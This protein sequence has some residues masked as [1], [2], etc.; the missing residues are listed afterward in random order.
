LI[1]DADIAMYNAKTDGKGRYAWFDMLMRTQAVDRWELRAD[2]RDALRRNEFFLVYQPIIDLADDRI[3]GAE[4]LLR[5]RHPT[6]G[7]IP[8]DE[9]IGVAEQSGLIVEIGEW[10]LQTAMQ[11]ASTWHAPRPGEPRPAI[12]INVSAVQLRDSEIVTC[13]RTALEQS[14]LPADTVLLELTESTLMEDVERT[15]TVLEE[16]KAL[17]VRVAV[18]DFGTGYSSLAYL[19]QFP[20]DLLKIDQAFINDLGIHDQSTTLAQDIITIAKALNVGSIAEGIETEAQLNSLQAMQCT[21]GQGYHLGRPMT[22][23]QFVNVLEE[24]E[25]DSRSKR[26]DVPA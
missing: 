17:G 20:V 18:D 21:M 22:A 6:R 1:R 13:V 3:I 2:L 4:A 9:F 10:V 5:W 15:R 19:R 25:M 11:E 24:R 8:P 14:G 23:E 12:S 16:L 7:L 26:D